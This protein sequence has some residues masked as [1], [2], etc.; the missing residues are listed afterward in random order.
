MMNLSKWLAIKYIDTDDSIKQLSVVNCNDK[1]HANKFILNNASNGIM[2]AT[3][4]VE[5]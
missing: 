3:M 5:F 2:G 1:V 4:V